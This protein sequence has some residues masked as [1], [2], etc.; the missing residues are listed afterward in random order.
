MS[1]P[2]SLQSDTRQIQSIES[3]ENT[4]SAE[5]PPKIGATEDTRTKDPADVTP[6]E[7]CTLVAKWQGNA[8]ELPGLPPSTTIAEIK[9]SF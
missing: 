8:I 1:E 9:V 7:S 6:A 2:A 3:N 5:V 4:S